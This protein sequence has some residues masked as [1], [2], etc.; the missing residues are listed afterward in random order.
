MWSC[1]YC[2]PCSIRML[3]MTLRVASLCIFRRKRN[4]LFLF[5]ACWAKVYVNNQM[6][7]GTFTCLREEPCRSWLRETSLGL[8]PS[9]WTKTKAGSAA[10]KN[11]GSGGQSKRH[12]HRFLAI[13]G[14]I[15]RGSWMGLS[16]NC[17]C[18]PCC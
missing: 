14:N 3:R 17:C 18:C 8:F 16:P 10:L 9:I 13:S 2:Y 7:P 12:I 1:T 4:L 15:N 5:L 6:M 11:E